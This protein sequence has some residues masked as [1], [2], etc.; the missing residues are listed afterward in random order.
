M[1][2]PEDLPAYL[3]DSAFTTRTGARAGLS[4]SRLRAA[5]LTRPHHGVRAVGLD[6]SDYVDRCRAA[7]VAAG[8]RAAVSHVSALVLWGAPVPSGVVGEHAAIHVT[9][10]SGRIRRPGIVGHEG[11]EPSQF[12]QAPMGVRAIAPAVAWCQYAA[13]ADFVSLVAIGDFLVTGRRRGRRRERAICTIEELRQAVADHGAR[14]GARMLARALSA[15]REGVDSRQETELRLLL[16]DAGL[17]EPAIGVRVA[18]H[19]GELVPDLAYPGA[20]VILEYEGDHH[21]TDRRQW[22]SDFERVRAFQR[23]GWIVI[24]VNADDLAD[25][26]RRAS[27]V[28]QVRDLL[29]RS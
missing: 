18:T 11:A 1:T 8:E 14:R 10:A 9:T 6:L 26:R 27:L 22:R 4:R 12:V 3:A 2:R 19:L 24:R 20:R 17:P 13:D 7:A 21:R 16:V 5:D 25:A 29:A 23:A 15:I 28:A